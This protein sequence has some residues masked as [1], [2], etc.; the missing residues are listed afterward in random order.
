MN[1]LVV[2]I[3]IGAIAGALGALACGGGSDKPPLTPDTEHTTTPSLDDAGGG[4]MPSTGDMEP[5]AG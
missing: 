1:R 4:E 5:D 3:A 2:L